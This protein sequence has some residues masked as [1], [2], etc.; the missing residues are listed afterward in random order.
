M[1]QTLYIL[2]LLMCSAVLAQSPDKKQETYTVNIANRDSVVKASIYYDKME[3]TAAA[4]SYYY[5]YGSNKINYTQG[6]YEGRLLHGSY[7]S[8]YPNNNL[9][10]KG[11]FKK[12]I[13]SKN[14]ISW[15]DNGNIKEMSEWKNGLRNG[16]YKTFDSKGNKIIETCYSDNKLHGKYTVY[17]DGKASE[18][19]KYKNG[20]EVIK[21]VK[22][23]KEPKKI[24]EAKPKKS[25]RTKMKALFKK[26]K[27]AN[28]PTK[29]EAPIKEKKKVPKEKK[30]K[31]AVKKEEI[32]KEE[33][34]KDEEK[35][36][37][38]QPTKK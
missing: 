10:Q 23:I 1:K 14:W 15:Y 6:G 3:I 35:T 37:K 13:K 18:I 22:P 33:V 34:K 8:F 4:N 12:G 17:S 36:V 29:D 38:A 31:E 20:T 21:K 26:K 5:W 7:T 9:K 11:N 27:K 16:T 30:E 24:K 2:F 28:E 19:K 25:L 32:K